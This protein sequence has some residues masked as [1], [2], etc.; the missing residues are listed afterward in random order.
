MSSKQSCHFG[1]LSGKSHP[2]DIRS[3]AT[4]V[5]STQRWALVDGMVDGQ[6]VRQSRSLDVCGGPRTSDV[7]ASV[8]RPDAGPS[9]LLKASLTLAHLLILHS[10]QIVQILD[11]VFCLVKSLNAGLLSLD[12]VVMIVYQ[13]LLRCLL[14][15]FL[16][17]WCHLYI[18]SDLQ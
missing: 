3:S 5:R 11:L 17:G 1:H 15:Y 18:H 10:L 13:H 14:L 4:T 12:F 8:G 6:S 16:R 7:F 2:K 9:Y